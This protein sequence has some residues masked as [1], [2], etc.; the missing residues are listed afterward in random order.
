MEMYNEHL[1][2]VYPMGADPFK[3]CIVALQCA[4]RGYWRLLTE[5]PGLAAKLLAGN[6][7]RWVCKG[8]AMIFYYTFIQV[9]RWNKQKIDEAWL[10][11]GS[12]ITKSGKTM[13]LVGVTLADLLCGILVTP[14]VLVLSPHRICG[15]L[16]RLRAKEDKFLFQSFLSYL[17]HALLDIPYVIAV[18]ILTVSI[19]GLLRLRK[20]IKDIDWESETYDAQVKV[21]IV[22]AMK[23][24]CCRAV[25]AVVALMCVPVICV[26][27]PWRLP[28]LWRKIAAVKEENLQNDVFFYAMAFISTV[29]ECV[30]DLQYAV[31][32][33]LLVLSV[34]FACQLYK[35]CIEKNITRESDTFEEDFKAEI[36]AFFTSDFELSSIP[37]VLFCTP[38]IMCLGPWRFFSLYQR[39]RNRQ[40]PI[41]SVSSIFSSTAIKV[42]LEIPYTLLCIVEILSVYGG[43]RLW[44]RLG[45][46]KVAYDDA[47]F[48]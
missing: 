1:M 41:E 32:L 46:Y 37:I 9:F 8:F 20:G 29:G 45:I 21:E 3:L 17:L 36:L 16:H 35:N 43:F 39:L 28:G 22:D 34:Y 23:I 31:M 11:E 18:V 4:G 19:Y 12:E 14:I 27:G 26:V 10:A 47:S 5:G 7:P 48:E 25:D 30:K 38:V 15:L 33:L 13:I 2:V 40:E 24:L 44:K 6:G 42:A